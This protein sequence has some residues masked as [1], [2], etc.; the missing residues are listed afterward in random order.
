[1][2]LVPNRLLVL[3]VLAS[4]P[5][6]PVAAANASMNLGLA[7]STFFG[8][9]GYER[10]QGVAVDKDDF[11]YIVGN[12]GSPDLP[13]TP[14]AFQRTYRGDNVNGSS[15][16]GFVAKFSPDGTRLI[17]ATYLGGTGG[18]RIYNV[19]VDD[20]GRPYVAVWTSSADF[21]T[22]PGA[23]DTTHNSPG[24][25]DLAYAKLKP[26]G[27]G[28]VYSTFVGGAGTEQARGSLCLDASGCL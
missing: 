5:L 4:A 15:G 1:M 18:D 27:S 3:V 2:N 24:V 12:T 25:M 23:F 17:W 7:F 21:P 26:D 11:I 28:L 6:A 14:G 16:D 13:T 20:A 22:T 10:A 9:S 8:G 19:V